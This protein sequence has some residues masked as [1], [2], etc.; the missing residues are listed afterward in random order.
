MKI[1]KDTVGARI[2]PIYSI[3]DAW[4]IMFL[5]CDRTPYDANEEFDTWEAIMKQRKEG[6]K[7]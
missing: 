3:I 6:A 2:D 4:K 1:V 5:N 7:T